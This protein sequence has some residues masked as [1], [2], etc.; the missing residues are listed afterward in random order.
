VVSRV[1]WPVAVGTWSDLTTTI[2]TAE[3]DGFPHQG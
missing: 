2:G 3:N 1:L